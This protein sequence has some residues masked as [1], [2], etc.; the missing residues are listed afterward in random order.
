M[1]WQFP[2]THKISANST[3]Y[4]TNQILPTHPLATS[5]LCNLTIGSRTIKAIVNIDKR[6]SAY[7]ITIHHYYIAPTSFIKSIHCHKSPSLA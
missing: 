2:E 3:T 7:H 5:R 1:Q 6:S 4:D